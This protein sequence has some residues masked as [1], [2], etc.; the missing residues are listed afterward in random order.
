MK[1]KMTE[2]TRLTH[3]DRGFKA[4][5]KAIQ[6]LQAHQFIILK[7]RFLSPYGE[8]D[9]VA[10]KE[11]MLIAVEVKL[12]QSFFDA[13]NCISMRQQNRIEN[14]L[15]YF[16]SQYKEY[17]KHDLRMDVILFVQNE[18]VHIENAWQ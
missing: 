6:Y 14:A 15:L 9:I 18:Y 13:R 2:I 16:I 5:L 4:E 12:R 10:T 1:I 11:S 3:N 8:I 7:H 17:K